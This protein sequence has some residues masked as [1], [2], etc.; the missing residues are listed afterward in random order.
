M[1]ILNDMD[2]LDELKAEAIYIMREVVADYTG[3]LKKVW[4][5]NDFTSAFGG[6]RERKKEIIY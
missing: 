3:A 6:V 2:H 4:Y 5:Q 1:I